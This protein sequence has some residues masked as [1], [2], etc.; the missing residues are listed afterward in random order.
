MTI[1]STNKQ[2]YRDLCQ[3][4]RSIPIFSKDWWLDAV[5]GEDKWDVAI[6][7]KGGHIFASMPYYLMRKNGFNSIIMPRLTQSMGPWLHYP[8]K[9]KYAKRLSF[10]KDWGGPYWTGCRLL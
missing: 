1:S 7:E 3:L 4:E 5:C 2:K 9:Q 6:V 10:E 8:K